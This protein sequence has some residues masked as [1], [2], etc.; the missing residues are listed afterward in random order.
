MLF[1]FFFSSPE[2]FLHLVLSLLRR[3]REV[4]A[5]SLSPGAPSPALQPVGSGCCGV[6]VPASP[7]DPGETA[8]PPPQPRTSGSCIARAQPGKKKT[9]PGRWETPVTET[10]QNVTSRHHH[11]GLSGKQRDGAAVGWWVFFLGGVGCGWA[12]I[13]PSPSF[14]ERGAFPPL[15]PPSLPVPP[16]P[17]R[18]GSVRLG[19]ARPAPPLEPAAAAR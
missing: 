18:F 16:P 10:R 13:P 4:I 17:P 1:F 14:A 6:R 9:Q 7:A 12:Q 2:P 19:P 3:Q 8:P 15:S 11:A 5:P